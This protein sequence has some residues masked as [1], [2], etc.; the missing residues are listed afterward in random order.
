MKLLKFSTP[1]CGQCRFVAQQLKKQG[2]AY[3]EIDCTD[4]HGSLTAGH[5]NISHVPTV[6]IVDDEGNATKRFNNLPAILGALKA[7]EFNI[8]DNHSGLIDF[9]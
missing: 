7:G 2:I 1:T 5:Y 9:V 8:S 6:L 4:D 3:E